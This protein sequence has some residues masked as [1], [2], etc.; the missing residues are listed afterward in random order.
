VTK[1]KDKKST[2]VQKKSIKACHFSQPLSYGKR[3]V[4]Y[5]APTIVLRFYQKPN[6]L[7]VTS[8]QTWKI[9]SM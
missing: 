6:V 8:T 3:G 7:R 9:M 2:Q 1:K 4:D 5:I